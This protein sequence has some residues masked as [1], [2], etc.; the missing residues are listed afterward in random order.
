MERLITYDNAEADG[1]WR[2][3]ASDILVM[4]SWTAD[5]CKEIIKAADLL[6]E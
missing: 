3:V 1:P 6:N 2:E 4:P 5:F